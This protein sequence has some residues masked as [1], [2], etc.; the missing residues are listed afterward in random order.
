MIIN[1]SVKTGDR[2]LEIVNYHIDS[3]E[4]I[5]AKLFQFYY[6]NII[7]LHVFLIDFIH[8]PGRHCVG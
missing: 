5:E 4:T 2:F 6:P 8:A 7:V 1:Q 3:E